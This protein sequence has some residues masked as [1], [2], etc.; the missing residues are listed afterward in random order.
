MKIDEI[1]EIILG[2]MKLNRKLKLREL[3]TTIGLPISTIH[4]RIKKMKKAGI[5]SKSIEI[6]WK[7]LNYKSIALLYI[8]LLEK[9]IDIESL[10]Q[11]P[12]VEKVFRIVDDYDILVI[13]RAKDIDDVKL[14]VNKIR[15]LLPNHSIKMVVADE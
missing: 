10:K 13:I 12:F 3:S 9:D 7:K 2:E 4:Y 11:Y 15:S 6:N 14:N 1:D 8:K 5:L